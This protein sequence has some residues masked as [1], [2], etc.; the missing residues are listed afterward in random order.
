MQPS[1]GEIRRP[2]AAARISSLILEMLRFCH[3]S[4][5][6]QRIFKVDPTPL[7]TDMSISL[8][9]SRR[10]GWSC[11]GAKCD[12]HIF[13][14]P[15]LTGSGVVNDVQQASRPVLGCHSCM[16]QVAFRGLVD[17]GGTL[18]E[19]AGLH[20]RS[21]VDRARCCVGSC[22]KMTTK[23]SSLVAQETVRTSNA[24][25]VFLRRVIL[26]SGIERVDAVLCHCSH[27]RL[28]SIRLLVRFMTFQRWLVPASGEKCRRGWRRNIGGCRQTHLQPSFLPGFS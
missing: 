27:G 22:S 13:Q 15:S 18:R 1:A 9:N 26:L 10:W 7:E 2:A 8:R 11:L 6:R 5:S 12:H 24:S 3:D 20:G 17:V 4:R 23:C 25:N 16:P 21:M 19:C 28:V 14:C